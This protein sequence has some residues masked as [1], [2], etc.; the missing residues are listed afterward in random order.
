[1]KRKTI[2]VEV[3][4]NKVNWMLKYSS[5]MSPECRRG[6]AVVL[7]F[8]LSETGNYKGYWNLRPNE[9]P[10]GELPGI[11]FDESPEHN[12]QYPDDSRRFYY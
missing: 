10:V 4:K 11:I 6:M 9:V 3:L 2:D 12:H 8:A 7:K 1:M 5:Q